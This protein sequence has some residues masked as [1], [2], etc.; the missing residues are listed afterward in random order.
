MVVI[1]NMKLMNIEVTTLL[2][3]LKVVLSN[4]LIS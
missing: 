3:Q 4:V 1:L 2:Y